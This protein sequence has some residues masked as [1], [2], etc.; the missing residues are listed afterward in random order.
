MT[1]L[2]DILEAM[3]TNI[4]EDIVNNRRKRDKPSKK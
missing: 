2:D 4:T 1:K 3:K